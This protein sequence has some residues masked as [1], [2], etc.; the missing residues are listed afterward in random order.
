M[1]VQARFSS[2]WIIA[3]FAAL[4]GCLTSYSPAENG[5]SAAL[6]GPDSLMVCDL[7]YLGLS[8][9]HGEVSEVEWQAFLKGVVTPRFPKGFT[10]WDA[11]G[12]WQSKNGATLPERSKVL[13]VIHPD[14]LEY[15]T[16]IREIIARYKQMFEQESVMRVRSLV[17]VSF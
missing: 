6:V 9:H 2:L 8:K 3:F 10:T 13:Q 1:P 15:E 17:H 12:R 5:T 11:N 16:A 14:S 7:L 4:S